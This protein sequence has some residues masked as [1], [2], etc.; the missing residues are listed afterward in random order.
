MVKRLK[1]ICNMENPI[2]N[3]LKF[4]IKCDILIDKLDVIIK[5]EGD[6]TVVVFALM[7]FMMEIILDDDD[8]DKTLNAIITALK[9]QV[10]AQKLLNGNEG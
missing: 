1:T 3:E 9:R 4:R 6:P 5:D 10:E 7:M 8:P 2:K